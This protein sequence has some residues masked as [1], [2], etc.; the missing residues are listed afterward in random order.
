[1]EGGDPDA[2]THKRPRLDSVN[3][4]YNGLP[5][6]PQ[7]P[8]L[9][10]GQASPP[11]ARSYPP[12]HGLPPPPPPQPYPSQGPSKYPSGPSPSPSAPTG[13]PSDIR[14][15][16]SPRN[17]PSPIQRTHG[18]SGPPVT[19]PARTISQDHIPTYQPR[20]P[21][22]PVSSALEEHSRSNSADVKPP[23]GMEHGG[24]QPW[25]VNP[26]QRHNGSISNGY[27]IVSPSHD[28]QYPPPPMPPGQPP[29]G[30]PV[31]TYPP[32]QYLGPGG[33][34]GGP[35]QMR[36]KQVRATQ[37]CNHCRAR[38]QKCDEARPC[39]FCREN[40]F[41]CQYKDVPP[42]KQDRSMMQLQD[43]VNN[44]SEVL[45][46]FVEGINSWKDSV[47]TWKD[48]VES[49]LPP[50]EFNHSMMVASNHPSPEQAYGVR[51]SFSEP[52]G[53]RMPTPVQSRVPLRRVGSMKN[54][55]PIVPHSA[56][57]PL[58][59]NAATPIKQESMMATPQPPATPADSVRT[60]H[61]ATGEATKEKTGLLADHETPAHMLLHTW[62]SMAGFIPGVPILKKLMD[63]G[64]NASDYAMHVEQQRGLIRVWGVGEG[65]DLNDGAQ[66][67][68]SP[69]SNNNE[70]DAPSPATIQE[71]LWGPKEPPQSPSPSTM[72]PDGSRDTSN[73]GGLGPDGRPQLDLE[74]LS[75]LHAS[76]HK[77]IHSL[78]P[79]LNPSKLRKMVREFGE[80]Y[81]P[82]SS[83][84]FSPGSAVP[85]HVAGVKRKRSAST[86]DPYSPGRPGRDGS[87]P[88]PIERSLRNAIVLLVLALGKVCEYEKPLPA[89]Q[90]DKIQKNNSYGYSQES[91]LSS[92]SSDDGHDTR[93][94]N[95][96]CMPGMGYFCYATDILGN[97][98][99]GNTIAHA[100]AM[101]LA[102]L[103]LGQFA[104]VLE[105]W[106]WINNAC[107][108][109]LI[110]IKAFVSLSPSFVPALTFQCR[111]MDKI[112]RNTLFN[113]SR[114]PPQFSAKENYRLNLIKCVYWT[115]LQLETDILAEM[116]TLPP[117]EISKF[118]EEISYP[119]G[120]F[121]K[122]PESIQFDDTNEHEKTMWTYSSQ[123]HLRVILNEAH[124]TLY[125]KATT[126]GDSRGGRKKPPGLDVNNIKE[127]A[128]AAR[129]HADILLSWRRLLPQ[130][131]AWNDDDPP[132]T[133][134]NIARLR[135]KFYGGHYM[136][137][138]PF[139]FIAAH[140]IELPPGPPV[141]SSAWSSQTSSPA[142]YAESSATSTGHHRGL[143]DL[144]IEQTSVLTV[145]FQCIESAIRSTIAFDRV[146]EPPD[147]EYKPYESTPERRPIL[148]NIF[149]TLHAQFGNMLVLAAVYKSRLRSHLPTD[150]K[151]TKKNL[152][153][154][155]KR[156]I[157]VLS[158]VAPNSP[159][160]AVDVEI[161]KNVQKIV[162]VQ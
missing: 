54:E 141:S 44:M 13:P 47:N 109:C 74:T 160:L 29:Y 1:M 156:T 96:D 158:N 10:T 126:T 119:S 17:L 136:I 71:G 130:Q 150:T 132:A 78:H 99:G 105:S 97:Q 35:G 118:Q 142:A 8:R 82:K 19:L 33:S 83:H 50:A 86:F 59:G 155:F 65:H 125:G 27:P 73:I 34:Y 81:S 100:Q 48:S 20:P 121:E 36:R 25:P 60:D 112:N 147:K 157:K 131:L 49:R 3:S 70:S 162:G 104:R 40:N 41:D 45:K 68:G 76:Y 122:F 161:L 14:A 85:S 16:S 79:F 43:S 123:I 61:T 103:Y 107:R 12:P 140:E 62:P 144:N 75:K 115:C 11:S 154:L 116:S 37:A 6:P 111:D 145:A 67:P 87:H 72:S 91:P 93:P 110:L 64:Y 31:S 120:V 2:P 135:A 159:I 127:V 102:A 55:S 143:M 139:L 117:S 148:T 108:V 114:P 22:T 152:E 77:H 7:P 4:V 95:M 63:Q 46:T 153:L 38:K 134:I 15:Y 137:L 30:Q 124:N 106:S 98:Q 24:H 94:R 23:S 32:S 9:S 5:P 151:L 42:P 113:T 21:I 146:Y 26:E 51:N 129:V 90:R 92:F 52:N 69:E 84:A 138:R 28:Q 133:D 58:T 56:I 89:P 101:L 128:A 57:S 18:V 39:Q 80:V 53:S 149:G 88:D 66:G